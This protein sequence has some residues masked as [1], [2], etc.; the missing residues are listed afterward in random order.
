M[1]GSEPLN[2]FFE[3]GSRFE[4]IDQGSRLQWYKKIQPALELAF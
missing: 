2:M 1:A 4:V 3:R